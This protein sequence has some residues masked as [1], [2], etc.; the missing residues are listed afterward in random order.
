M[1]SSMKYFKKYTYTP[2]WGRL[3][4]WVV[5]HKALIICT[6]CHDL[7][8]EFEPW[9]WQTLF[10]T[11][12]QHLCFLHDSIW[13]IWFDTIICLSNLSCE[14][15]N[16][17]IENKRIFFLQKIKKIHKF[18]LPFCSNDAACAYLHL[19]GK[20]KINYFLYLV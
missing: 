11:Q 9:W 8:H 19:K 3:N 20:F 10:R 4:S 5:S 13:F 18:E 15:W 16:R 2:L 17:K 7:G 12:A 6:L 14:L 1:T